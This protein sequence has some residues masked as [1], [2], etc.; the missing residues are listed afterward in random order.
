MKSEFGSSNSKG[1]SDFN[2][3]NLKEVST[4]LSKQFK[5]VIEKTSNK[6]L[7]VTSVEQP[8]VYHIIGKPQEQREHSKDKRV[9]PKSAMIKSS[10]RKSPKSRNNPLKQIKFQEDSLT[11]METSQMQVPNKS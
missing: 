11:R 6:P 2:D 10:S 4:R 5:Q 7:V 1:N 8:S 9:T 3:R